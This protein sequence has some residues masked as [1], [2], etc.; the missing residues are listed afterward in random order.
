ML[1]PCHQHISPLLHCELET[2]S[3]VDHATRNLPILAAHKKFVLAALALCPLT[4]SSYTRRF[5]LAGSSS[6]LYF[7]FDPVF[8]LRHHHRRP[9]PRSLS[10]LALCLTSFSRK[11]LPSK[12]P[13]VPELASTSASGCAF[14]RPQRY[15]LSSG[16]ISRLVSQAVVTS[17]SLSLPPASIFGL[18]SS[19]VPPS[20]N[21][22]Y[23]FL[24]FRQLR[25]LA[26]DILPSA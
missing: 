7:C 24:S 18:P 8:I 11:S 20:P 19:K 16:F 21:R 3:A 26:S 4:V 1:L 10:V 14:L 25:G 5:W 22:C 2:T 9:R 6:D 12:Q 13:L 17:S 15:F 23:N